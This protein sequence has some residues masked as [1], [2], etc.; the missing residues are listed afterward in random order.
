MSRMFWSNV[1]GLIIFLSFCS[2]GYAADAACV[3]DKTCV[4]VDFEN[5]TSADLNVM[6][7]GSQSKQFFNF[8]SKQFE[9]NY[10][11]PNMQLRVASHSKRRFYL[12][13][14]G[15]SGGGRMY[16]STGPMQGIPDLATY[17]Y[18]YDKIELGWSNEGTAVWN[19]TS[20]DFFGLAI[21]MQHQAKK[22]GFK[23]GT[24][25]EQILSQLKSAMSKE[26]ELFDER[27]I[28]S[29]NSSLLRIF[30]PQHFYTSLPNRW[31]P[32]IEQGIDALAY[33]DKEKG[34]GRFFKFNYGGTSF[35][36]IRKLSSSSLLVD[37][38]GITKTISEITTGNAVAG[39]IHPV[40]EQFAGLLAACINRGVLSEPRHWG[41]NGMPNNAYPQY[42]YAGDVGRYAYNTY[43]KILIDHAID[44]KLYATS[45]GDYWHMDSSIQVGG[46]NNKPVT[47]KIL[48]LS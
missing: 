26:P 39:Q 35:T 34:T 38:N 3:L 12:P 24:T 16:I 5:S 31:A 33:D 30:S 11:A 48:P 28:F 22:I 7:H 41:E 32:R 19:T 14:K 29:P 13:G 18:V 15:I 20:V 37:V 10:S 4:A 25:R 6:I 40:G 1:L 23:E 17:P 2:I 46:A 42:Y 45:Y 47:I 43:A 8:Q 44:S 36:N 21:Q 27:F 9:T